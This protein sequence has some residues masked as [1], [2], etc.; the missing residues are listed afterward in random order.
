MNL[1]NIQITFNTHNDNKN[2]STILQDQMT[3]I[4]TGGRAIERTFCAE[5]SRTAEEEM[6]G[7]VRPVD[8]WLLIEFRARWEREAIQVFSEAVQLRLKSLRTRIPA[9]RLTLIRQ[10]DRVRG[11]LSLFW[12][13]SDE[14]KPRLYR[15]QFTNYEDLRFDEEKLGGE[16][17]EKLF[18]VCTHGRHDPC[19]ARFGN[20][21]YS[22]MQAICENVWQIS[23]IGGCRFAPNVVC[24]P[25][26][27]VYGRVESSECEAIVSGYNQGSLLVS[28]A[29]GRSCYSK[30]IQA[31][32]HFLRTEKNLTDFEDLSLTG[33]TETLPGQWSVTFSSRNSSQYRVL[34]SMEGGQTETYKSCSAS[35]L[36]PR[37][38]FRLN[39][40]LQEI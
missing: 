10:Q 17:K 21:I 28:R 16:T 7:T 12:A 15:T 23:H 19:C 1:Q 8:L 22:R 14:R 24:L 29:R 18:A 13:F 33:A 6:A 32:E 34:L 9:T 30:P 36:L 3:G 25:H 35:E 26:G 27:I 38:R 39:D 4:E 37:A 11:P 20:A 5:F 2:A 40:C 31:A